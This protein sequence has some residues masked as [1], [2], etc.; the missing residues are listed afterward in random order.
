MLHHGGLTGS[1]IS[2]Q[3]KQTWPSYSYVLGIF[4]KC[5]SVGLII[6]N[7]LDFISCADK[8]GFVN[9]VT[10]DVLYVYCTTV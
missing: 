7:K 8:D 10:I 3:G 6:S 2:L 4:R 1:A 5:K 9:P